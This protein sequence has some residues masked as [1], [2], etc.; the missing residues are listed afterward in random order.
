MFACIHGPQAA[1]LAGSFSP[2]VESVDRSTAV[3]SLTPRQAA[4]LQCGAGW[5]PA[6]ACQAAQGGPID[7]RPQ[8]NKLPHNIAVA[9]TIEAAVLAARNFPGFTYIAPGEEDRVL[10]GLSIDSLP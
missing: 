3:F 10:G 5:N 6:A 1:V 2:W 7:N 8:L 9:S 4:E